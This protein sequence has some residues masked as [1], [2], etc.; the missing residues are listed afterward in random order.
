M[1]LPPMVPPYKHRYVVFIFENHPVWP[2]GHRL[3]TEHEVLHEVKFGGVISVDD[4][5]KYRKRILEELEIWKVDFAWD[6]FTVFGIFDALC[7]VAVQWEPEEFVQQALEAEH[8]MKNVVALPEELQFA[9]SQMSKLSACDVARRRADFFAY[10]SGRAKDLETEEAK[11][12]AGM[13]K[14]VNNAVKNKKLVLFDEMLQFYDYPDKG[15]V[16]EL[17]DG[18]TL[19]GEVEMTHMLP[20]KFVPA[21]LTVDA[22]QNQASMRRHHLERDCRGSGDPDI[23]LE[24]WRQTLEERDKGWL[25]GPLNEKQVP[26]NASIS[27]RFGLKQRHKVRLIDDYFESSVNQTVTVLESPTLHTVDVAAALLTFWMG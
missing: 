18:A 20:L 7:V 26:H 23:D 9:V 3:P 15:A 4:R 21:L 13:D 14:A 5:E 27:R 2:M 17:V 16:R 6:A 10:W 11:L 8:P 12:R 24:V 19:A 25:V 1:R 22:L